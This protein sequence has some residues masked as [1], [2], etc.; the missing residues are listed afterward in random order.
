M[1]IPE[2]MRYIQAYK[3]VTTT[4]PFKSRYEALVLDHPK[5]ASHIHTME[6]FLPWHRLM[7]L[8]FE[9][10]LQEVDP[11]VALPYWDWSLTHL[12]PWRT[13]TLDIWSSHPWGLGGNGDDITGCV[14]NGPFA[15]DQWGIVTVNGGSTCLKR[16]FNGKDFV[17]Y[18]F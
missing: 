14:N 6:Q 5:L 1:S 4:E 12:S 3:K 9:K 7:L 2:R 17:F 16:K 15:S 13:S 8:N 11:N 18:C 10:L